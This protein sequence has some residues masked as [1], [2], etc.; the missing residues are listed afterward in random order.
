MSLK[1]IKKFDFQT[2]FQ[3]TSSFWVINDLSLLGHP[4]KRIFF[5]KSNEKE[6]RGN[7]A[8]KEC[9]QTLVC[10]EGKIVLKFKNG[11]EEMTLKLQA[12]GEAVT[13][14]PMIWGSQEYEKKSYLMVLCSHIY[15]PEDYIK[16]YKNY[17]TKV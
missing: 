4:V 15:D 2:V 1:N 16:D 3:P 8:H 5:N 17:L 10:L 11:K 14:P 12:K 9:W 6:V 13:M 7:H